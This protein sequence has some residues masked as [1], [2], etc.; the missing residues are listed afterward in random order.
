MTLRY[1]IILLF[2]SEV[3]LAMSRPD[4]SS[5]SIQEKERAISAGEQFRSD[6]TALKKVLQQKSPKNRIIAETLLAKGYAKSLDRLNAKS[7]FHFRN[8]IESASKA[9]DA[10]LLF[11]AE[12]SYAEYLYRYREM[13]RALPLF[14][15]A[16]NAAEKIPA[17]ELIFPSWSYKTIGYYLGTIGDY[18]EAIGMLKR[19]QHHTKTKSAQYAEILDNIGQYH[20]LSGKFSEAE[21]YFISARESAK[22][23]NDLLRYAKTLGNLGLI[24]EEKEA[25][26]LAVSLLQKDIEISKQLGAHQNTMFAQIALGRILMKAGHA[27]ESELVLNQALKIAV[28][29]PHFLSSRKQIAEI[30]IDLYQKMNRQGELQTLRHELSSLEDSLRLKDGEQ[31]LNRAN[32]ITQKTLFRQKMAQ[33]DEKIRGRDQLL[34]TIGVAA[35]LGFLLGALYLM[36]L[37]RK[38]TR[39]KQRYSVMIRKLRREKETYERRLNETR[40]TV[41]DQIEYLKNKKEHIA[42]LNAEIEKIRQSASAHLE[43]EEGKLDQL[44]QSHLMTDENWQN[45]RKQFRK[46]YPEF[47]ETLKTEFPDL[48]AAN[49]RIILLQKLGFGPA[50]ISGLLGITQDAV[51]KSR[52][53]LKRRLGEKYEQLMDLVNSEVTD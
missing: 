5:V 49:L 11:W 27:R 52:Q 12:L 29:R 36:Q 3:A 13:T 48:T 10:A 38:E 28:T 22:E 17:E 18:D 2:F 37:K 46:E 1:I 14:L 30:K 39:R 45:F 8:S 47:Y 31:P 35:T 20:Y 23:V 33:A 6:T 40:Q 25:F 51:K 50:E 19:A 4:F 41:Q 24:S 9:N 15:K 34:T 16:L 42:Q 32:L 26:D 7:N 44:L 53:R 43:E 21:K